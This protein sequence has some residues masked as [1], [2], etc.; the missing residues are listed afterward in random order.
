MLPFP[1]LEMKGPSFEFLVFVFHGNELAFVS[2]AAWAGHCN[3]RAM[4]GGVR[5]LPVFPVVHRGDSAV[6][7]PL[8]PKHLVEAG[9]PVH[10]LQ[11]FSVHESTIDRKA[12]IYKMKIRSMQP[13]D[14]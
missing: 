3:K 4:E 2:E 9:D 5:Q 7:I 6:G 8:D 13:V 1:S 12:A 14:L 11:V 10:P